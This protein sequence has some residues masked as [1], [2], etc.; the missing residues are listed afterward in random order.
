MTPELDEE[1]ASKLF[2]LV[3]CDKWKRMNLG[4][5]GGPVLHNQGCPHG[6]GK[7]CYSIISF[8]SI[9]GKNGGCPEYSSNITLAWRVVYEM[10]RR[11]FGMGLNIDLPKHEVTFFSKGA[12]GS[13]T[14]TISTPE[15]ICK[16]A[17]DATKENPNHLFDFIGNICMT[18]NKSIEQKDGEWIHKESD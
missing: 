8:T 13:A 16:A 14:S 15:A 10:T 5:L 1:I 17:L 6:N 11:D 2:G 3:P 12:I 7:R 18:C 9:H 4:S